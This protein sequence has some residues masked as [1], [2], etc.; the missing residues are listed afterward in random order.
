MTCLLVGYYGCVY[1]LYTSLLLLIFK[2]VG[3]NSRNIFAIRG[4]CSFELCFRILGLTRKN[5]LAPFSEAHGKDSGG[6]S[7]P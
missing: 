4:Y 7:S 6:L 5:F 3:V 2:G 1:H